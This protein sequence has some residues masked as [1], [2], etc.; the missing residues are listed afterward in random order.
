MTDLDKSPVTR[1][2]TATYKGRRI[3]VTLRSDDVVE[4][5]LERSRDPADKV[6]VDVRTLFERELG[7][8]S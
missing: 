5:R 2:A 3:I 1:R 6:K 7:V 4:L 8:R